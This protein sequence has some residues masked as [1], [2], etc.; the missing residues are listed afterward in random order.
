M[1][2]PSAVGRPIHFRRWR[3]AQPIAALV[4][5][6]GAGEEPEQ[7]QELAEALSARDTI[8]WAAGC[9][10]DVADHADPFDQPPFDQLLAAGERLV[11]LATRQG[12]PTIFAGHGFG[13]FVASSIAWRSP[14]ACDGIILAGRPP[15]RPVAQSTANSL[16]RSA[17]SHPQ[18]RLPALPA[19][20]RQPVNAAMTVR[21]IGQIEQFVRHVA[22]L[23]HTTPQS[24]GA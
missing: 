22:A 9:T 18:L 12:L 13:G 8:V 10:A 20:R 6:P 11:E 19:D 21:A 4:L 3:A 16:R 5:F 15:V 7:Y 17:H 2:L 14:Q 23:R 1:L 24:L